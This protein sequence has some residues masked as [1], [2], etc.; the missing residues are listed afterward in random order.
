[1]SLQ[2]D[3]EDEDMK[4]IISP[5]QPA[6]STSNSRVSHFRTYAVDILSTACHPVA[7]NVPTAT[8]TSHKFKLRSCCPTG[9]GCSVLHHIPQLTS[10]APSSSNAAEGSNTKASNEN[11]KR[12]KLVIADPLHQPWLPKLPGAPGALIS[13]VMELAEMEGSE[14]VALWITKLRG[15]EEGRSVEKDGECG[16]EDRE[17][18]RGVYFGEYR[19]RKDERWLG[20]EEFCALSEEVCSSF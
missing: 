3:D 14:S 20:A 10:P 18:I 15:I 11:T 17:R 12:R 16:T 8:S 9:S 19:V 4:P 2:L 1:M 13:N 7:L 6:N 5:S